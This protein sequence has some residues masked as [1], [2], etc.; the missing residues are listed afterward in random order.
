MLVELDAPSQG[1]ER[2]K[3]LALSSAYA[4]SAR[5]ALGLPEDGAARL[6][7]AE[8]LALRY[9]A[10]RRAREAELQRLR[11]VATRDGTVRDV[12]PQLQPGTRVGPQ[13]QI[14]MV[15]DGRRWRVE[16][17]VT[18][19]D[20]QRLVTGGHAVVMVKGRTQKPLKARWSRSTTAR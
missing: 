10:E 13:Q 9:D 16:A 8:Q 15:V 1:E 6:A 18:E 11:I 12:D 14:A 4:R 17:L 5:S 3:A 7:V 19:R 2:D 20:R